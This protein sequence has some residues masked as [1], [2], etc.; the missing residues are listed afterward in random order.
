LNVRLPLQC[1]AL[2]PSGAQVAVGCDDGKVRFLAIDGLEDSAFFV[3]A[4][5]TSQRIS[6]GLGRLFGKSRVEHAYTC[7]CPACRHSFQLAEAA[8]EQPRHC[9]RCRRALRF[10]SAMRVGPDK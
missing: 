10:S 7:I 1:A 9:P 3:T 6:T 4:T 8:P 2:A 5:R